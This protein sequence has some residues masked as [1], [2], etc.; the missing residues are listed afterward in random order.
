MRQ[1]LSEPEG[2]L[3]M[4]RRSKTLGVTIGVIFVLSVG[5]SSGRADSLYEHR[6][7]GDMNHGQQIKLDLFNLAQEE[8]VG[9]LQHPNNGKHL[10]FS[11]ASVRQGPTLDV[12]GYYDRA[13][14]TPPQNRP[15]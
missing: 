9:Y 3:L 2:L 10:G 7:P 12:V 13:V 5:V 8:A 1:K 11:V 15:Q 6:D 14:A 4:K